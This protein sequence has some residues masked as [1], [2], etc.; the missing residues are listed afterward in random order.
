MKFFD[1]L[2]RWWRTHPRLADGLIILPLLGLIL[3]SSS[4]SMV[5]AAYPV[6]VYHWPP[7]ALSLVLVSIIVLHMAPWIF[8]R[9]NPVGSAAVVVVGSL[10]QLVFGPDLVP[11]MFMVLLTVQNLAHRA[12]RWASIGGFVTALVGAVLYAAE[13]SFLPHFTGPGSYSPGEI[14]SPMGWLAGAVTSIPVIALVVLAWAIGNIQRTRRIRMETLQ[15][16]AA[17]LAVEARQERELAAADER[18]RIARELHDIV[19]HSLQVIISQADGGRYAAKATPEVAARTLETI[20]GTGR[21]ALGQMRRLLGVLRDTDAAETTPQPTLA[22]VPELI[23]TMRLAGLEVAY[24]EAAGRPARS[25][26]D[27]AELVLYR[28]VQEALTNVARHAG[29]AARA[30]VVLA[31]QDSGVSV[32]IEDD[33]TGDTETDHAGQGLVGMRE[34]TALYDGTFTAGPKPDRGFRV[35]AQLPYENG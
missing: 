12:P 19:A 33:G 10:I 20:S 32:T 16:R 29:T 22:D 15:T 27:G 9:T 13:I 11:S 18:N 8:R 7:W 34:R 17:Q 21:D 2:T 24:T 25:L 3:L 26:A 6:T 31:W 4:G 30:T 5:S 1:R 35:H 28:I 14:L 23:D